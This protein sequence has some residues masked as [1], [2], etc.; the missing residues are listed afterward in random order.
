MHRWARYS[1]LARETL[2]MFLA[3]MIKPGPAGAGGASPRR[4]ALSRLSVP[5]LVVL[6]GG[7]CLTAAFAWWMAG[8]VR[9]QAQARFEHMADKVANEVARR[10]NLFTYG[11]KGTRGLFAGSQSVERAEFRGYV[12]SRNLEDEFAGAL[13]VG[14]IERVCRD[15][16]AEFLAAT[17]ADEAPGFEVHPAGQSPE[18][19]VIK[20]IE[21]L[22][23]NRPALGF[24]I[25]SDPVRRHAAE[26]A[27]RTGEPVLTSPVALLQSDG[28][29]AGLLF[30][31]PVYRRGTSPT[32]PQEREA[33]CEGWVFMPIASEEALFHV[34]DAAENHIDVRIAD[35]DS[36]RTGAL[37]FDS[38]GG[39]RRS[40]R[41][42]RANQALAVGGRTWALSLGT[43]R[44]FHKETSWARVSSV[45]WGGL[46][47]SI[48]LYALV[49]GMINQAQHRALDEAEAM[50]AE[51]R[52]S[53]NRFEL[54]IAAASVGIWDWNIKTGEEY[55]S[56]R[57]KELLGYRD[58][59]LLAATDLW[60]ML[61][62]PD[63]R[64]REF[65]AMQQHLDHKTPYELDLRMRHKSGEYRWFSV[66][67]AAVWDEQGVAVRM[68][69]SLADIHER[70]AIEDAHARLAAIVRCSADAILSQTLDGVIT[71][72][73]AAAVRM[74]GYSQ[75][76]LRGM[77]AASLIPRDLAGEE[78]KVR[79]RIAAREPVEQYGT[80]RVRRGG[81]RFAASVTASPI[82]DQ[83]SRV[84]GAATI[85]RDITDRLA[86]EKA[87]RE[88]EARFELALR[89]SNAGLWV[90]PDVTRDETWWSPRFFEL[91]G[92]KEGEIP[93]RISA[94]EPLRHPDDAEKVREAIAKNHKGLGMFDVEYRLRT[95][96]GEYRWFHS[97]GDCQRDAAGKPTLMA[98]SLSDI[99]DR[100]AAEGALRFQQF[101]L[102]QH[103]IVAVTDRAGTIT[104]VNDKFCEISGYSREELVGRNHRIINSGYHPKAFFADMYRAIARGEVWHGEIRNRAKDGHFYWVDTTI[105]PC[106]DEAGEIT[107]YVAIRADITARKLAEEALQL[108]NSSLAEVNLKLTQQNQKLEQMT[109]RAHRFVD[110][111]S[112]EFRTPLTVIKEFTS[113]IAD[114][115]GGPLNEQQSEWLRTIEVATVDLNQMVEDFLDS[116]KLRAGRLRVDRC[117]RE[118]DRIFAGVRPLLARKAAA[119]SIRLAEEVPADLPAVFADEEKVRRIIMNL[120]TNAI[121]FSPEGSEVR[122]TAR[123]LASGDVEIAVHD[124]G[125]G[126]TPSDMQQLFER[127]RQLP[128]AMTPSVKGFGLGL[129]IA[130]QL[131]WLNL[132]RIGVSSK[133]GSGATF[134]F[135]LPPNDPVLIVSRFFER[136]RECEEPPTVLA[137]L[138]AAPS[139]PEP[140]VS[141]TRRQLAAMTRPSDI[142]LPAS[143]GVSFVLCG[144]TTSAQGWVERL[145]TMAQDTAGTRGE[146]H[147][148]EVSLVASWLYPSQ[149]EEARAGIL[150]ALAEEAVHA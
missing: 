65:A 71:D 52:R 124:R 14:Y 81:E 74:F 147:K 122:L 112:H 141:A 37:L 17:R 40:D 30:L 72:C 69:G 5:P 62:H 53:E 140:D 63:D 33:A 150:A 4:R 11:L 103:A 93:M 60:S 23:P 50:T 54:A 101:A 75:S 131:A 46:F 32:T 47:L 102:D 16:L 24:D 13:G 68:A 51:L 100:K 27:M 148:L 49:G 25:A 116:S 29:G 136:L 83:A 106:R 104:Y 95:K 41:M 107:Q 10:M 38:A 142:I 86:I 118:V 135:T 57:W 98:G 58:E 79:A 146:G 67:G 120:A 97:R 114:G 78:A 125:P 76:E 128:N 121:K 43:T 130:R 45:V 117:R 94:I 31:L 143:D 42:F 48:V 80:W 89:G 115:L 64:E 18:L 132:G 19:M 20:Y 21:P 26:H 70:K 129:N 144:P 134:S 96:S 149:I 39:A 90:W 133:E 82:Y 35:G 108:S 3:P 12:A 22:E 111:V 66:R 55:F 92:Y 61:M 126:L 113:I 138:R 123:A 15:D 34:T 8:N 99:T 137:A 139:S 88:S 85:I 127:F 84:V 87:L 2:E 105:V 44:A 6:V 1:H 36:T 119:R 91:L 77:R 145:Q 110:D 28:Q 7:L 109:D 73:N 56:P 9:A 59:E